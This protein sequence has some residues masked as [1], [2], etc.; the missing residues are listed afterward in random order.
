MILAFWI[1]Y[2][3]HLDC[4][5]RVHSN[6][7][8]TCHGHKSWPIVNQS[9][10]TNDS[11]QVS[12]SSDNP[13]NIL[14]LS[15]RDITVRSLSNKMLP[16]ITAKS[17]QTSSIDEFPSLNYTWEWP[18]IKSML[19]PKVSLLTMKYIFCW[20]S[21]SPAHH[22][23]M[24]HTLFSKFLTSLQPVKAKPSLHTIHMIQNSTMVC[25][26]MSPRSVQQGGTICLLQIL[27]SLFLSLIYSH[28]KILITT[29]TIQTELNTLQLQTYN[30]PT[31]PS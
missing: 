25:G 11:S 21:F 1:L 19:E 14:T 9:W 28:Q 26:I 4:Q 3:L 22:T 23:R 27:C 2:L 16:T 10:P 29:K 12:T 15:P 18:K 5:H 30:I 8:M 31:M 20:K 17:P 7:W 24:F 13:S 6:M